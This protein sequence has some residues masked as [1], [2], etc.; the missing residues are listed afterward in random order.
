VNKLLSSSA[1]AEI[2]LRMVCGEATIAQGDVGRPTI[3]WVQQVAEEGAMAALA[4]SRPVVSGRSSGHRA[5]GGQRRDRQ[6]G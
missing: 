5:G 2:W 1:K 4:A 6:V 3:I